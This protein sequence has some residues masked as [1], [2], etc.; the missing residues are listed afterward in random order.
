MSNRIKIGDN[1]FVY[2]TLRP[3]KPAERKMTA[4]SRHIGIAEINARMYN[5]GWYP[6][7][8]LSD[9]PTEMVHGDVFEVIDDTIGPELDAYEGYPH[10]Y[11]RKKVALLD[12]RKAWVYEY[13]HP[14]DETSRVESG[15]WS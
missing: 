3:G 9:D 12:G 11:G 10:L 4:K 15:I 1:I 5:C 6:G 7:I 14:V 8:K 13:N 2:G